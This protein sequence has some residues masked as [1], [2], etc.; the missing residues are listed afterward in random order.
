MKIL[1]A[2]FS[3]PPNKD[4]VSEAASLMA[5]G[6]IENGWDVH[7]ATSPSFEPR[8]E[9]GYKGAMIHQ[10]S[11]RGSGHPK[12]PYNGDV[13]AYRG[14]LITGK[15]DVVIIHAYVWSLD[16][17]LDILN[18]IPSRK[19]LVSHGFAALQW[20]RV[21][22]FPWGL[23]ALLRNASKGFKMCHWIH[24]F[25]RVVYLSEQ[26]DLFG[27]LDHRIAK[28]VNF[29]GRRVIPNG[30]DPKIHGREPSSFRARYG[31][32]S[33][34]F[35][36]VCVANYSR[37]KNQGFAARSFRL[38]GLSNSYLVFIGSD[39]NIHSDQFQAADNALPEN[40][41]IGK[42][43][44]LEKLTRDETLN[45]IAACDAFVLS[46]NHEAQPIVLLEAMRDSKPWIARKAGC[47]SEMPGG[48]TIRTELEMAMNMR[49]LHANPDQIIA[50]GQQGRSAVEKIYNHFSYK[51][52]YIDLVNEV[53]HE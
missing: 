2:S 16:L 17:V 44:W 18:Q 13:S 7:I 32:P 33:D 46:A 38:S 23:G 3:F 36:F 25:D 20:V 22:R 11:V 34:C 14:F 35:L 8:S 24:K 29:K 41:K 21:T 6:F 10:F 39:F 30:V 53:T 4:G 26:A 48:L 15:W 27:F 37:R 52:K 50:L 49:Q 47:I 1:I 28:I 9:L 31:I 40:Q 51:Q 19:I 12:D 43:L 45:A 5:E 42:I